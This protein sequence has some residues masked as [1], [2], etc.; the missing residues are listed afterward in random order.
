MKRW[1]PLALAMNS[2]SRSLG[3]ADFYPFVIPAPAYDKL[4]YMHGLI[5]KSLQPKSKERERARET[6]RG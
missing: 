3:Y 2:L 4:E 6:A 5:R 1:I